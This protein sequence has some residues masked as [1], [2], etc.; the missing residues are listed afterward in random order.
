MI[1]KDDAVANCSARGSEL[2]VLDTL[3]K[4]T[5]MEK[6]VRETSKSVFSSTFKGH[7]LEILCVTLL[8]H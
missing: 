2:I 5:F 6:Y 7:I 8:G 1:T 3:Q 4:K